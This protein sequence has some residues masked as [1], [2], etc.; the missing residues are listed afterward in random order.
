MIKLL[1]PGLV[2]HP[3]PLF[4]ANSLKTQAVVRRLWVQITVRNSQAHNT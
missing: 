1:G 2:L 3:L 4:L